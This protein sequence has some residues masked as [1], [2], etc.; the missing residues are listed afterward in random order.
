MHTHHHRNNP[1]EISELAAFDKN[2]EHL[3]DGEQQRRRRAYLRQ[4]IGANRQAMEMVSPGG[5]GSILLKI[6]PL[7]WPILLFKSKAR[8][9]LSGHLQTS[10]TAACEYWG[11]D[12]AEFE[13][14]PAADVEAGEVDDYHRLS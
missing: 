11:F 12:P 8:K 6:I 5:S 14:A 7:F 2:I 13:D 1:L 9:M 4:A 10:T 3:P